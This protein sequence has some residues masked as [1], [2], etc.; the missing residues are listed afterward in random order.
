MTLEHFDSILAFVLIITGVSLIIT[1]LNQMASA[2]LGLRGSNL[3][4]GIKTL[5]ANIDPDLKEHAKEISEAV[6]HHSLIS[7][8]SFSRWNAWLLRRWRLASAIRQDELIDILRLLA[9]P[10]PEQ[11]SPDGKEPWEVA[12]GRA[13]D[14]LDP[15]T[16]DDIVLVA[17]EL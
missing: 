2:L 5:L 14:K 3:R 12:L 11:P 7:D 1:A 4:W 6:L 17:N 13:L 10:P 16:A 15:K 8:S 9:K